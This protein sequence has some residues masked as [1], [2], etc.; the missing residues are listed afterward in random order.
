MVTFGNKMAE[1]QPYQTPLFRYGD[2]VVDEVR[3]EVEIV[4]LSDA[5]IPWPIGKKGRAKTLIVY[6]ALATAVR[7]ESNATVRNSGSSFSNHTCAGTQ[8]TIGLE[9]PRKTNWCGR[10]QSW[11]WPRPRVDH[12]RG[13]RADGRNWE[14]PNA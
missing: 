11:K 1:P 4:S 10:G 12:V 9:G 8:R 6:D 3:G 5:K 2:L 14:S 7:E 13:S